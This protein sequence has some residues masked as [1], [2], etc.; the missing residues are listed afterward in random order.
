MIVY[1]KG[2]KME[3]KD[4]PIE[5]AEK[6]CS[7]GMP[8]KVKLNTKGGVLIWDLLRKGKNEK[9]IHKTK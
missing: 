6:L 4:I 5:L 7:V 9:R 2:G 8:V 1:R 3:L